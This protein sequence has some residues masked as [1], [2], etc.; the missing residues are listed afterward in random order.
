MEITISSKNENDSFLIRRCS[1]S[2]YYFLVSGATSESCL[3]EGKNSLDLAWTVVEL[4]TVAEKIKLYAIC[5][6]II[7]TYRRMRCQNE[8]KGQKLHSPWGPVLWGAN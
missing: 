5:F 2:R 3:K 4:I 7:R 8:E 6:I 1:F